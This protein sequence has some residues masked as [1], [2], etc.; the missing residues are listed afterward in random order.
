ML[1]WL[2]VLLLVILAVGGGIA[3]SKFLF[4]ILVVAL[5]VLGPKRLPELARTLGKAM[6]EFRR[7]TADIMDEFQTQGMM[8]DERATR[9][10]A[11]AGR[12]ANAAGTAPAAEKSNRNRPG[13][14]S[15]PACVA[16]SPS[17]S[18]NAL[19]TM[20]VAV[21]ARLIER[22]RST[23]TIACARSP[24]VTSP[25]STFAWCTI[26]PEIGDCTSRTSRTAPMASSTTPWSASWPPPSA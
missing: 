2:L 3:L 10:P 16:V 8:D 9:K 7:Q 18:R 1:I 20:W 17:A 14:F 26:I 6:A 12:V 4:L 22:R 25:L 5:V 11:P 21:C 24:R 23:S 19:C 13:A 15:E